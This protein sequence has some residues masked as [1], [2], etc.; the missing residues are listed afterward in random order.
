MSYDLYLVTYGRGYDWRDGA[1]KPYHWSYYIET[2]PSN[3][4]RAGLAHQLRGMPGA[5]YYR[6]AEQVDLKATKRIKATLQVGEIPKDKL[7]AV[8]PLLRKV[9]IDLDESTTW[10]C[11]AWALDAFKLMEA[12]G[13]IWPGYTIEQIKEWLKEG[14]T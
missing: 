9:K 10:N 12:Q 3:P 6:G 13:W 4:M 8:E 1:T 2:C 11:Q 5:F 14:S 7:D